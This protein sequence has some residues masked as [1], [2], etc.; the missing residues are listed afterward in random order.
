MWA[1]D[2]DQPE[3]AEPPP[4]ARGGDPGPDVVGGPGVSPRPVGPETMVLG[5]ETSLRRDGCGGRDG[6]LRRPVVGGVEPGRPARPV[7]RCRARDRRSGPPRAD[8][9]GGGP[10][11][12]RGRRR[13]R[14]DR[15]R[16]RDDR[17]RAGRVAAR[18]G[19]GREGAGAD[20]GRALR[21]RQP[22]RGA[23]LR[24]LPGGARPGAAPRRAAG[25]GR[26]H[27]ARGDARPRPVPPPRAD[28]RRRRR[29]GLRQG[30]PLPRPRVPR[31]ARPSTRWPCRAT[32]PPSPSPGRCCRRGSTSPS[33]A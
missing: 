17:A 16:G 21:R 18:R 24:R 20:V 33:V 32:R 10:G 28:D 26:P 3:F 9:A 5:I 4:H 29:R 25:V 12:R 1:H 23:P 14:T 8:H 7:R 19:G 6:R 31:R 13:R 27:D 22:P 11:H 15:R 2:I 30:G